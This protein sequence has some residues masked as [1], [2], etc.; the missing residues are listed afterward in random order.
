MSFAASFKNLETYKK[1]R[2]LS[3]EIYKV[4]A[5][6]P[7]EERYSLTDQIR[8]SSRSVGAQIAESWGKRM[9]EKHFV[10]KLS[11]ADAENYETNHWLEI[12]NECGYITEVEFNNLVSKC[13]LLGKMINN[14]IYKSELFCKSK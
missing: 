14:M 7:K 3:L 4:S 10:L 12:A 13:E 2:E 6:F 5:T 8:R 1:A 9:Y 11:D